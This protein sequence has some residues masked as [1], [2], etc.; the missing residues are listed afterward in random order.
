MVQISEGSYFRS[1][2]NFKHSRGLKSERIL[3]SDG[4]GLFQFGMVR[5][6]IALQKWNDPFKNGTK[7][8]AIYVGRSGPLK[9]N[10]NI[11]FS[12]AVRFK[13]VSFQAPTVNCSSK[14]SN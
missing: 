12:N 7:M 9:F 8:A 3:I 10:L 13:G 1:S 5:F 11:L 4:K 6:L 2:C 14:Q